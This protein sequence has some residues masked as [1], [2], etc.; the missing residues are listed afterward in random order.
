MPACHSRIPRMSFGSKG[1]SQTSLFHFSGCSPKRHAIQGRLSGT[2]TSQQADGYLLHAATICT[3]LIPPNLLPIGVVNQAFSLANSQALVM[4]FDPKRPAGTKPSNDGMALAV[5]RRFL[6]EGHPCS[7][8][9]AK[10]P[11]VADFWK[12]TVR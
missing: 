1:P 8:L 11:S 12:S 7:I 6:H 10:F 2:R 9:R 3:L 4:G 5:T